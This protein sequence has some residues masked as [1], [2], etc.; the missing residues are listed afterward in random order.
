[1]TAQAMPRARRMSQTNP[2]AGEPPKP[3]HPAARVAVIQPTKTP[4]VKGIVIDFD[5]PAR[6]QADPATPQLRN[7]LDKATTTAERCQAAQDHILRQVAKLVPLDKVCTDLGICSGAFMTYLLSTSTTIAAYASAC[8]VAADVCDDL[9]RETM[10]KMCG[11]RMS[12][13]SAKLAREYGISYRAQA[14]GLR[15]YSENIG[16]RASAISEE[17]QVQTKKAKSK[18]AQSAA[19]AAHDAA[20]RAHEKHL[21]KHGRPLP[22]SPLAIGRP[23][24]P[25]SNEE[26]AA[27]LPFD[28]T[29]LQRLAAA[30][31]NDEAQCYVDQVRSQWRR[32]FEAERAA[33]SPSSEATPP[34]APR[35]STPTHTK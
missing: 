7:A 23:G 12:R 26:L 24:S 6:P 20:R 28:V 32:G 16:R 29:E 18:R 34:A 30:N 15:R 5:V 11:R 17:R 4:R 10:Q 21:A 8:R 9:A 33:Q 3:E 13:D 25:P 27:L 1:M 2:S 35:T 19:D 31:K 22:A 14:E